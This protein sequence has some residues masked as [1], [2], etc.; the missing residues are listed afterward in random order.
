KE[1]SYRTGTDA[2]EIS[3]SSEID[4]E[5]L[6]TRSDIQ[7]LLKRL[8]GM[9]LEGKLF[10]HRNI[11]HPQRSHYAL[12]TDDAYEKTLKNM[13]EVG[14]N[15]L[16]FVPV[17]EPRCNTTV[18]LAKDPEIAGFDDSKYVFTDLSFGYG[19]Q[20]R[21]VVVRETD[22]VL[23][24]ATVEER[25]RMARIYKG[26]PHRP[27]CEPPVFKDP[28]LQMALDRNDHEHVLDWACH[29]YLPDDPVF[30][31]LCHTIFDRTLDANKFSNLYSTRHFGPFVFYLVLNNRFSPL[32]IY[33]GSKE[34]VEDAADLIRLIKA[35]SGDET[36]SNCM[37]S[38]DD[39]TILQDFAKEN[40]E[41]RDIIQDLIKT[42]KKKEIRLHK[43]NASFEREHVATMD[44]DSFAGTQGPL[45][46]IAKS[47]D[48]CIVKG[49]FEATEQSQKWKEK[50]KKQK[51]RQNTK[52][53]KK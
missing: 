27:V 39:L 22:G 42:A 37:K 48:V 32:L 25:D 41:H 34:K 50:S 16:Q 53:N 8:T 2:Q 51:K 4:V 24:S 47:Y 6:F 9:N 46:E 36:S 20:I 44:K 31:E 15:F 12:M 11:A 43:Q 26:H 10:T 17:L 49:S 52:E 18:I 38:A 45:G 28:Y 5:R 1:T 14:L 3:G 40:E 30:I 21:S 29:Y 19:I 13:E 35:I 33:Y 23:R 7:S